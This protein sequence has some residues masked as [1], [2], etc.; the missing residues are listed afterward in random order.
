MEVALSVIVTSRLFH[1]CL[2]VT[3]FACLVRLVGSVFL[4][5]SFTAIMTIMLLSSYA[6]KFVVIKF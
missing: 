2:T 4:K 1:N 3:H 5:A 6:Y